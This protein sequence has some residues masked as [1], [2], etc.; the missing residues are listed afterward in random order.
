MVVHPQRASHGPQIPY[1]TGPR[2][3]RPVDPAACAGHV[4]CR[5]RPGAALLRRGRGSW[6]SPDRAQSRT[7]F[8]L[9]FC[10]PRVGGGARVGYRRGG[11]DGG[12]PVNRATR[13]L[14][15]AQRLLTAV[16]VRRRRWVRHDASRGSGTEPHRTVRV[17]PDRRPDRYRRER[18]PASGAVGVRVGDRPGTRRRAPRRTEGGHPVR[19]DRREL[20]TVALG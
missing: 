13:R 10:R 19:D 15:T 17:G 14:L 16:V 1:D 5:N 20:G 7:G 11:S 9:A 12:G 8:R 6:R 2:R 4:D 18:R 3:P